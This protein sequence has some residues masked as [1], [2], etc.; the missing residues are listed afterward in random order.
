[1]TVGNIIV[2]H[3]SLMTMVKKQIEKIESSDLPLDIKT[4]VILQLNSIYN[5]LNYMSFIYVN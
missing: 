5:D 3:K 2:G 4:E 1:M